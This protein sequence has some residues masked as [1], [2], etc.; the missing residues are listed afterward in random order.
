MI[1][2]KYIF[3]SYFLNSINTIS[4]FF[5]AVCG[6]FG[7]SKSSLPWP[8]IPFFLPPHFWGSEAGKKW[9]KSLWHQKGKLRVVPLE[10]SRKLKRS[11]KKKTFSFDLI[12]LAFGLQSTFALVFILYFRPMALC[13]TVLFFQMTSY[14]L[15]FSLSLKMGPMTLPTFYLME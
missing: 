5:L 9:N 12:Y 13:C 6:L 8:T 3:V 1:W 10:N 7:Y 14:S 4:V 11:F 2:G 15:L